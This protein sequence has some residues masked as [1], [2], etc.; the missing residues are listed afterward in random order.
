MAVTF[1]P[2]GKVVAC[3]T[4]DAQIVFINI[5][6]S[7]QQAIVGN[8]ECKHDLGYSRKETDKITAKKLQF[9]KAFKSLSYTSD[10][11]Y[12]IAGGKSKYICI[13][14]C[15]EEMLVKRFEISQN[16]SFDG[17][18]EFLD[19]R[20]MTEW[21]NLNLVE[22]F[23]ETELDNAKI[24]L[25]GVVRGDFSSR[26]FKPEIQVTCVRFSPTSRS[27]SACSTEGLLMYSLDSSL[28]FDPFDLD[29]EI[30]PKTIRETLA[31]QDYSLAL[32]Q[33]LRLNE[34]ALITLVIEK[35]PHLT[36]DLVVDA[37]PDVYV[38]KLLAFIAGQIE[39][40]AHLEF[41]LTWSQNI[42]YRHGNR[43]KQRATA[44]MAILCNL[45]KSLTKKF[46]DL[47]RM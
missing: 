4:L 5:S 33:A 9:G 25:P 40:S 23:P 3:S 21:G 20:K 1:R 17:I 35:T 11:E 39:K 22:A 37:L 44:K 30:T 26:A 14:N 36:V 28:I 42:L 16:K 34:N 10:G 6:E 24:S 8:I 32:M 15:K 2:D 31:Q 41:Y 12:L 45:E 7:D 43:I 29:I 18:D 38:D 46:E 13:Y 19:R 47:S 27:W